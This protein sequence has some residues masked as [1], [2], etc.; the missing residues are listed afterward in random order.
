MPRLRVNQDWGDID[1]STLAA[2][3][4]PDL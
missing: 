3:E 1:G 4:M 2:L